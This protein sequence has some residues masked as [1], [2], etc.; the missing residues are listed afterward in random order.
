ML[1]E[2]DE[3]TEGV[4]SQSSEEAFNH[5][6]FFFELEEEAVDEPYYPSEDDK[7]GVGADNA[8]HE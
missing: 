6:A 3:E 2:F 7:Y 8:G 5:S 1:T 4:W